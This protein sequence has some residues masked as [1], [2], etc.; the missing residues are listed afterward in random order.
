MSEDKKYLLV[1]GIAGLGNRILCLL[2]A[3]LYARL[4][5]RRL[6][7]DWRDRVYS[8]DESDAFPRFFQTS[9]CDPLA[10]MPRTDSVG[11][12]IWR[13]HL[14]ESAGAMLRRYPDVASRS[15]EAWRPFSVDLTRLNHQ[16]EIVVMWA[17]GE[18]IYILRRHL[19]AAFGGLRRTR[20]KTILR[21]L[22]RESLQLHPAIQK[23]VEDFRNASLDG[24]TVGVHVRYMDKRARLEAIYRRLDK[25][26][27]R[28]PDLRI[29]LSTDNRE[30]NDRFQRQ[31]SSVVGTSK[32][33]PTTGMSMHH[34]LS[35]PDRR[36][37]GVE[38]LVDMYL[39]AGC[40]YLILDERSS[41]SYVVSLI[42]D[43]DRS[44]QFNVQRGQW[45]PPV[46]RRTIW[47]S[48]L[49]ISRHQA[50]AGAKKTR[51]TPPESA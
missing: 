48:W 16:E 41:F 19:T 15:P 30:I 46:V 10:E 33:Y 2:T 6:L 7:V 45:I 31:Y 8:N 23:R 11:P 14:D 32:W 37:H 28:E 25:L 47:K 5:G 24:K 38:A 18:Q 9:V 22:L 4:S 34:N 3:V 12:G 35:S 51:V 40:T 29:F 27:K 21:T 36:A 43:T 17:Y 44:N 39:L 50:V 49:H 1:K 42:T 26:L 20:T 13:G